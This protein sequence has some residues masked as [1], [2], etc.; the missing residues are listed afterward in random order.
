MKYLSK[1]GDCLLQPG[2]I[3][4]H[5]ARRSVAELINAVSTGSESARI[6]AMWELIPMESKAAEATTA[7][8]SSLHHP[9][10]EV[11]STAINTLTAL[12]NFTNDRAA[13]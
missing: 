7:V 3:D 8:E 9:H 11:R 1:T 10:P 5:R 13:E 4:R 2:A 12:A 6:S